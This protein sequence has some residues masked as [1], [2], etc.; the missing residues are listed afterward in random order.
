MM[1]NFNYPSVRLTLGYD[2]DKWHGYGVKIPVVTDLSPSTNSHIL[3]CGMSGS[4]KTYAQQVFI[5]K[6]VL[7]RPEGEFYFSDYKGEDSFEYLRGLP[8]YR[9]FKRTLELLDIVYD[10][11]NARLSGEDKSRHPITFVWD[12]YMA[13]LLALQGADKEKKTTDRQAPV[14]M[15]KVSEILLMGRSMS[16]RLVTSMQRP[17]A[18]AFPAG[19]RLNYGVIVILGAAIRSIYEMLM[20]DHMDQIK[21]RQFERGEGVALLQG[22]ELH[23]IKVPAVRDQERMRSIC[24]KAL[25]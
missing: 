14:A 13:N 8:R 3:I 5:A 16:V 23:F 9:S 2:L 21:G 18:I 1:M 15:N 25:S 7:A 4:G 6:M 19:S 12:E 22:S 20:P 24:V 11:L 17:D 10:R